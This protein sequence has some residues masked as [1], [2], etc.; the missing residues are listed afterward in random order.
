ME[1]NFLPQYFNLGLIVTLAIFI[2]MPVALLILYFRN[3]KPV[4]SILKYILKMR[5]MKLFNYSLISKVEYV[6]SKLQDYIIKNPARII[7]ILG[8][9]ASGWILIFFEYWI[10]MLFLGKSLTLLQLFIIIIIIRIS[11]LLP[12]PGAL[13]ALEAAHVLAMQSLG[14]DPALGISMCIL[15]RFR[16]FLLSLIGIRITLK[17]SRSYITITTEN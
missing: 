2:T 13:G 17:I 6:E 9:S 4:S 5:G 15:I 1:L 7:A 8:I 14:L 12:L 10:V 11:F 3:K 16:D